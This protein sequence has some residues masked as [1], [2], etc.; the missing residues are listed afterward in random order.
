MW[1]TC[2]AIPPNWATSVSAEDHLFQVDFE[3]DRIEE[4]S[5]PN[6]V[7]RGVSAS[8]QGSRVIYFAWH[9]WPT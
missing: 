7:G 8:Y 4:A 3:F 9:L 6:P 5:F 2:E 1:S